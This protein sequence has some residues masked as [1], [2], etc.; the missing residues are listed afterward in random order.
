MH[1]G[2][3]L[4][5]LSGTGEKPF[6]PLSCRLFSLQR[7]IKKPFGSVCE[8]NSPKRTSAEDGVVER[9]AYEPYG[10]KE[11]EFLKGSDSRYRRCVSR[12]PR[13]DML[14]IATGGENGETLK[15]NM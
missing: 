15:K 14:L 10:V 1:P 8:E 9:E 2:K 6:G 3:L 13:H 4:L 11:G 12:D 7:N 5:K